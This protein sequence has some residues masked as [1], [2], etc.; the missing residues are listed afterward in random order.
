MENIIINGK[1]LSQK[2]EIFARNKILISQAA[3]LLTPA[4]NVYHRNNC[5]DTCCFSRQLS[6]KVANA[7]I[8]NREIILLT[9]QEIILDQLCTIQSCDIYILN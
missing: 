6:T 7:K 9:K 5:V 8:N 1:L 3:Y 4:N 2:T